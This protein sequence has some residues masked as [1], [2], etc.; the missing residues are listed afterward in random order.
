MH[1]CTIK[2]CQSFV[3]DTSFVGMRVARVSHH[4]Y[5]GQGCE[6]ASYVTLTDLH[7]TVVPGL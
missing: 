6:G 1:V 5:A 7:H 2:S 4:L 3:Q